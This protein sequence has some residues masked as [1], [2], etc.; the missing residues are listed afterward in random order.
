MRLLKNTSSLDSD[1]V[2]NFYEKLAEQKTLASNVRHLLALDSTCVHSY[3][4]TIEDAAF[5]HAKTATGFK[6]N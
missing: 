2:R 4:E 6:T 5:G 1:R 3:S